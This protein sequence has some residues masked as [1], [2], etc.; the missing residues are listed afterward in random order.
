MVISHKFKYLY[1]ELPH[2]ASTAI[3]AELCE[4]YDGQKILRKHAKYHEFLKQANPDEKKYFVFS[5]IRNPLDDISSMY[6]KFKSN[7]KN[8]FTTPSEW[9]RNGGSIPNRTLKRYEFVQKE[10][11]FEKYFFK[12]F[13]TPYNNWSCLAHK[14]FDHVI[15]FENLQGDFEKTLDLLKIE[16]VRP[17]PMVNKTK[18]KKKKYYDFYETQKLQNHALKVCGGFMKEWDYE[19]PQNWAVYDERL[20]D[21]IRYKLSKVVR[22]F[23]YRYV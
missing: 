12:Y 11:D 22:N 21:K 7:H 2:T 6:L 14:D 15:K 13:N 16:Q 8:R 19:R 4:N 20:M 18:L 1:I 3:S 5:G 10:Q 17:L 9:K 23:Y